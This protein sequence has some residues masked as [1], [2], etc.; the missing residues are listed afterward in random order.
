M[1]IERAPREI[2]IDAIE[3]IDWA[4]P[5]ALLN[6]A[7]GKGTYIRV[8][9]EDLGAAVGSCAHLAALRRTASGA[10]RLDQ[11]MTLAALEAIDDAEARDALLLPVE[12]LVASMPRLDVDDRAAHALLRDAH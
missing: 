11:A 4:P 2:E 9:A 7:C 5:V 6:V 12:T 8:L 10:F 1:E 3:L